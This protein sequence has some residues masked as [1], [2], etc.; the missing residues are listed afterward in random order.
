MIAMS[1]PAWLRRRLPLLPRTW[2]GLTLCGLTLRGLI[3]RARLEQMQDLER[4]FSA[5]TAWGQEKTP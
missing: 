5:Q 2:R 4:A 3:V 1:L